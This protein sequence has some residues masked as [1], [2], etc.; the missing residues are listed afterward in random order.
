VICKG[1]F[2]YDFVDSLEKLNSAHLPTRDEFYSML[3]ESHIS[4]DDY[5]HAQ[6]LWD[7]FECKTIGEYS[8]LYLKVDVLLLADIFE[9]FRDECLNTYKLDPCHYF[10]IPGL[11]WDAALKY[12]KVTLELITDYDMLKMIESGIRRGITQCSKRHAK[13]NNP[14]ISDYD[15]EKQTS[16]I[17]YLDSNNLY[18]HSQS[19]TLP[20]GEFEWVEDVESIGDI[21]N[22]DD[23]SE[24]G[25]IL[26]LDV[27]YPKH[28]HELHKCFIFLAEKQVPPG[29]TYPKLLTTLNNKIKY[30]VHYRAIKQALM[31]E[32]I[33]KKIHRAIKFKQSKWLAPYIKL[34]TELRKAALSAFKKDF[35][36][37]MN[38]SVFGKTMECIRNRINMKLVVNEKSLQKYVNK[39]SFLDRTILSENVVAVHLAKEKILMCKPV[40]VGLT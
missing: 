8:D 13:A 21:R 35:Y 26:E 4:D 22:L 18:S 29:S 36:K 30:V 12:T 9:S 38:I 34:N 40:Y 14:L 24:Y 28:L 19:E 32:L 27:E 20:V 11:P 1:V 23:N 17:A 3:N 31:N 10:T 16:H 5:R 37:L 6:K 15:A 7:V 39:T 33:L 25:Y 2:C